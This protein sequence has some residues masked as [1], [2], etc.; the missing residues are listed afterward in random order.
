MKV[1]WAIINKQGDP[2]D[3]HGIALIYDDKSR[4]K[5]CFSRPYLREHYT[6]RHGP[7]RLRPV[8][9]LG[10]YRVRQLTWWERIV[11]WWRVEVEI[12][13]AQVPG[14]V[15]PVEGGKDGG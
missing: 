8:I 9:H 11:L 6:Q 5:W 10:G 13:P 1:Q 15:T 2:V 3:D 7:V 12:A 4:A 14:V